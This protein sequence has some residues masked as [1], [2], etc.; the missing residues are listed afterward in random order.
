MTQSKA[1]NLDHAAESVVAHFRAAPCAVAAAAHRPSASEPAH[2]GI[3]AH[4]RLS[5]ESQAKS[6]SPNTLF[7]LASVTK[8][9]TA[10]TLAR[11]QKKG[12]LHRDEPLRA[13]LPEL[14]DTPTA[15]I[16][17]DLLASHRAGLDGHRPLYAPLTEGRPVDRKQ[18]LRVAAQARRP[19]CQGHPPD[20]EGFPPI[21]SDL[22]YLL[23][24]A[25]LESRANMPLDELMRLEVLAPLGLRIASARQFSQSEP[26]FAENTA[27][28]EQVPFRGGV[29]LAQVHDENAWAMS[30]TGASGHAGLFGDAPSVLAL[31]MALIQAIHNELPEFLDASDMH[32]I[33]RKRPGGSHRAGFDSR[34][35]DAPSS[36]SYFGPDTIGHLGFTGTSLWL[37]PS[38][39]LAAVLLSNR[40][41]PTRNTDAIKKAR[42]AAYDAMIQALREK[43]P[44]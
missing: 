27:P 1:I 35:G 39:G 43:E 12:I 13:F 30:E 38:Q 40:V 9:I 20:A 32:P 14:E 8:P 31:G 11:L 23:L 42:P 25:C 29:V 44:Q 6:V 18:A 41:H 33:L 17:L 26:D 24:G 15:S 28:T 5:F 16:P 19:E 2:I 22:G 37:D 10:L 36:G 34:S 4:G 7:D 3:G 21:Y